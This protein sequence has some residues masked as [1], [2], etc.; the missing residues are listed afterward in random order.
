MRKFSIFL[1]IVFIVACNKEPVN[2]TIK[3]HKG[4]LSNI[5]DT[6]FALATD[7]A[8]AD[9]ELKMDIYFPANTVDSVK[10]PLVVYIHSGCYLVG[11]KEEGTTIC[12]IMADSGF[13][14]ATINYRLGWRNLGC[15]RTDPFELEKAAYR[16]MQDMNAALRFLVANAANFQID[17]NWIFLGGA[18]AGGAIALNGSYKD[19]TYIQ[20]TN[21]ELFNRLGGLQ[22]SGNLFTNSFSI[23]GICNVYGSISDSTLI[24]P[25]NAIPQISFHGLKDE[26]VPSDIGYFLGCINYQRSYGSQCIQRRLISCSTAYIS[27]FW[28]D[29]RHCDPLITKE[30]V[31]SNTACFFRCLINNKPHS[32]EYYESVSSCL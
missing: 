25:G 7:T 29:G 14:A 4:P 2:E 1:I 15:E 6:V 24:N 26:I 23:K 9:Q 5:I 8:G 22:K 31:G 27:H 13:V 32:G 18:S 12:K 28:V 17:T 19:D 10:Y 20:N 11:D 21:S 16:G 30:F 3:E